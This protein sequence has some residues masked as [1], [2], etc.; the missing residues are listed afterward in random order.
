MGDWPGSL[1]EVF[2]TLSFPIV[3]GDG[4]EVRDAPMPHGIDTVHS[5][6]GFQGLQF[7][8]GHKGHGDA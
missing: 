3:L 5:K 4:L 7:L 6:Q 8:I 2:L 1:L